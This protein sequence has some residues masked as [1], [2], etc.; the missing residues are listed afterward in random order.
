MKIPQRDINLSRKLHN[1]THQAG[2]IINILLDPKAENP[3][4][5]LQNVELVGLENQLF[6]CISAIREYRRKISPIEIRG[7]RG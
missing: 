3:P 4:E 2:L 1:M 5:Q 6:D 7:Q